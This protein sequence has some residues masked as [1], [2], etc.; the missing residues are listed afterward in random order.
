MNIINRLKCLISTFSLLLLAANSVEAHL[1]VAQQGTLNFMPDGAYA[2]FSI[3]VSAFNGI[4]DDGDGELSD[5]EFKKHRRSILEKVNES[6]RLADLDGPKRL[7]GLMISPVKHHDHHH[8][9]TNQ[10]IVMG[11]FSNIDIAQ[12]LKLSLNLFGKAKD[13]QKMVIQVTQ[14]KDKKMQKATI[15]PQKPAARIFFG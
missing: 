7:D 4:D 9:G 10:I 6:I 14:F 8:K 1:M 2:V 15:T 13:E 5:Q 11:R 12:P 3:P